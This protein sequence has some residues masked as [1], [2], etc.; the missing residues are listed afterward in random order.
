MEF[1]EWAQ[2]QVPHILSEHYNLKGLQLIIDLFFLI[3]NCKN[4]LAMIAADV[5]KWLISQNCGANK[6]LG[7]HAVKFNK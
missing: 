5:Q 2:L 7:K 3:P 1:K 6:G 4:S